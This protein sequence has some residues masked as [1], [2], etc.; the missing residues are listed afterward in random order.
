MWQLVSI[1]TRFY[2]KRYALSRKKYGGVENNSCRAPRIGC[3]VENMEKN[4]AAVALGRQG[5][6]A[7]QAAKTPA[8]RKRAARK[9]AKARWSGR[10]K[11]GQGKKKGNYM[12]D[13]R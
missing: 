7:A 12:L 9:A 13:S 5:G 1:T 11:A 2:A 4:P 10:G 6:I 3:T 8:Q